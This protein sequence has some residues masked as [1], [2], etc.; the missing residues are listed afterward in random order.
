MKN[1]KTMQ[2]KL[3]SKQNYSFHDGNGKEKHYDLDKTYFINL[4]TKQKKLLILQIYK[5]FK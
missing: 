5:K 4:T 1:Q 2:V 3:A